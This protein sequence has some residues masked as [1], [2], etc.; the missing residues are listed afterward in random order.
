VA[1]VKDEDIYLKDYGTVPELASGLDHS[2]W[3]YNQ[4]RPHQA[5]EYQTPAQVYCG[6]WAGSPRLEG[7]EHRSQRA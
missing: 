7:G 5:L 4:E 2:W 6:E 1:Q 3:F